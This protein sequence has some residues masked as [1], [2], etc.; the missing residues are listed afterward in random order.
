MSGADAGN[1]AGPGGD[2]GVM[3]SGAPDAGSSDAGTSDAGS[4]DSGTVDAGT[5][6]AGPLVRFRKR[7]LDPRFLSEG[8]TAADV[9]RDG[10]L[11]LLV[12]DLWF[13]GPTWTPHPLAPVQPLDPATQYSH[14]FINFAHDVDGDGWVDQLVLGFPLYRGFWRKNPGA[15]GGTWLERPLAQGSAQESPAFARVEGPAAPPV[16]LFQPSPT[17]LG[18]WR[19][20]ADLN[21]PWTARTLP[22]PGGV[23]LGG[24]GLGVGDVDGDGRLDVLTTRGVF[25]APPNPATQ[26]WTFTAVDLGPDCAQLVVFDMNADG[27]PDVAT[28][29]AHDVGVWWHEQRRTDAGLTFTRH[30]VSQA[31][32]Q[33]HAL[34]AAEVDGDG[35]L[36]LVTGKR[37]WAHGPTGDVDPNGPRVLFWFQQQPGGAEPRFV[38]HLI[39]ADSGVG[40]QFLAQDVTGDG[41]VDVFVANKTGIHLF[42]QE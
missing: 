21:Q 16:A 38:P 15:D 41:K 39:D 42:V 37:L 22:L 13:E 3:D 33:S 11:D 6:D 20:S 29:S 30:L 4:S 40:T 27:L 34:A 5:A 14:S 36:D 2:A 1:D 7:T 25:F 26:P 10:V 18:L 24:H 28:S 8:A 9:N 17:E 23:S 31:F 19:P 32:S 12:G 35:R